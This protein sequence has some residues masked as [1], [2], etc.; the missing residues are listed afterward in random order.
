MPKLGGHFTAQMSMDM[1]Y[2]NRESVYALAEQIVNELGFYNEGIIKM[3]RDHLFEYEK[4]YQS[5]Y[6]S[7][8][9]IEEWTLGECAYEL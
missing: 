3:N 1:I 9:D 8:Y 5:T 7:D 6:H 2:K 4:E